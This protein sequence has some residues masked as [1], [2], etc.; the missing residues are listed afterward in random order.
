MIFLLLLRLG[1]TVLSACFAILGLLVEFKN[2]A[3][4]RITGWGWL[5]ITGT[6]AG[7]AIALTSGV[8]EDRLAKARQNAA[9]ERTFT[10]LERHAELLKAII[11]TLRPLR[12]M[13]FNMPFRSMRA[14]QSFSCTKNASR[15]Q[16]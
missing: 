10:E 16:R 8:L 1:G 3:T 14:T 2:K 13:G 4:G 6:V 15:K 12:E 5:S 9:N 7:A 11:R